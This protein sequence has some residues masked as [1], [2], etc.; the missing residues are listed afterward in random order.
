M[1]LWIIE[2]CLLMPSTSTVLVPL[3]Y[4]V[5]DFGSPKAAGMKKSMRVSISAAMSHLALHSQPM[6][7]SA[8]PQTIPQRTR[9]NEYNRSLSSSTNFTTKKFPSCTSYF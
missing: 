6:L 4:V 9:S 3:G 5:F 7:V 1:A 2:N 8:R